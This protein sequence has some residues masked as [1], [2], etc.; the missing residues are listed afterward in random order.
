MAVVAS[1]NPSSGIINYTVVF[2]R[3]PRDRLKT[4]H[5][6]WEELKMLVGLEA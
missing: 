2:T 5:L 4:A 1:P 6:F 3:G